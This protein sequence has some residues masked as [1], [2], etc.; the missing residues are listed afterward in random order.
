MKEIEI[1]LENA[2]NIA[3]LKFRHFAGDSDF[4]KMIKIVNAAGDADQDDRSETLEDIKN[5][6][7]HLNNS[8][9]SKDMIFAEVYGETIAYSR[10]EWYQEED[11]NDRIYTH[12]V[13]IAPEWREKGIE[14]AMIQWCE[15]RLQDI[16]EGHPQDSKRV[17]RTYSSEVKSPFN[18]ILESFG[19]VVER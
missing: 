5:Q 18:N 14:Q 3:G 7:S 4:P 1:Y 6:Y 19:Y 8:D 17:L 16:A 13:L 15:K 11:P 9:P 2:P 12:L 10:V